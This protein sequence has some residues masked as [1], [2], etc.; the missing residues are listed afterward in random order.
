MPDSQ[1]TN[2]QNLPD[3]DESVR[4]QVSLGNCEREPIH[5]PGSIQPHGGL[6]AFEPATGTI[7][8][9]S[10]N[11]GQWLPV[12]ALPV[13]G[14]SM[15]DVLGEE[16]YGHVIRELTG[17]VGGVMRHSIVELK[18][19]P[20]EGQP[21]PLEA[22]IHLYRGVGFLEVDPVRCQ[23]PTRDWMQEFEDAIDIL[24]STVDL[25]DLLRRTAQR[26][27]RLTGFD[28]VM[29]YRFDDRWNGCVIADEHE[30][31]ME[32][33]YDLH[34]PASDIPAQA[35]ELYKSNMVRYIAD[36]N[37]QPVPVIPWLDRLKKRPLDMSHAALRAISPIHIQY[38]QNMG[39]GSTLTLSLI[40]N[41]RL[42]G[43]IACHHNSPTAL[44]LR[45]SRACYA[46][47]VTVSCMVNMHIQR[48]KILV[49]AAN[50]ETRAR[51]IS[52]F[53]QSHTSLEDILEQCGTDL[54]KLGSASGGAFWRG[55]EVYPFGLWP[56]RE[57]AA[58]LID[59]AQQTLQSTREDAVFVERADVQPK[60]MPDELR[61]VCGMAMI[62]LDPFATCGLL[63]L[64]PEY[65]REVFW[66]G[67]PDKPVQLETDADGRMK[68]SPRSSFA[69][70][71]TQVQ[72]LSRPWSELDREALRGLLSLRE[73]LVVRDSLH[74]VILSNLHFRSLVNLQSDAYWQVDTS[75]RVQVLSKPLII[76]A[77]A[78]EGQKL[79][80]LFA[81]C[82]DAKAVAQL[83]DAL[84]SRKSFR[85]LAITGYQGEERRVFEYQFNGEPLWDQD[86]RITG[87]HG[88][89]SDL[90]ERRQYEDRLLEAQLAAD[91]ANA[92]K[93]QFLAHM[94]HEIRTPLNAILGLTQL[95]ERGELRPDERGL[96]Q[97]IGESGHSLLRIINDILD[98]SKIEAGQLRMESRPYNPVQSLRQVLQLFQPLART[99][100]LD[101]RLE[102]A[103]GDLPPAVM[104]D[105]LR[106]EQIL[107]NLVSN[108]IKFTERGEIVASL[109]SLS[110]DSD[111][112][113]RF[114][115]RDTGIG[116]APDALANLFQ[117]FSQADMTIT[118]HYGGT[119]LGLAICKRLVDLMGGVIG[120]NSVVGDGSTFWL[121]I[122][123][124]RAADSNSHFGHLT[125]FPA[126]WAT[127]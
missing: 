95:L 103:E 92:A 73:I 4:F 116:I 114:E 30:Q 93:S 11:V 39:V 48:Q 113:L 97:Q 12:G 99:K 104:G 106:L 64:R 59:Y 61:M 117:S 112:R 94:S 83:T 41:E 110:S 43:L 2:P 5:I 52:A 81:D 127:V 70:W 22:F 56:A 111:D 3:L 42:W 47:A 118:R 107:I 46:L 51:V 120:V 37:Y 125:R 9:S 68:L 89:I 10:R 98:L 75:G 14:R 105:T 49:G 21:L 69:R 24:R 124:E 27:K 66:G 7:L 88:T 86:G 15:S 50:D 90:S 62:S 96:V 23:M 20:H 109:R 29:I 54:L 74:Q 32:S 71:T 8:H 87:M 34:Y 119:G 28:R 18:A 33:F 65:R 80:E 31:G 55:D 1:T 122:P 38:L 100:G 13:M 63:W 84:N 53:N 85:N 126:G 19:R 57:R 78:N 40:V 91:E 108:A 26:V 76:G 60:L 77:N 36:V 35:R 44:P 67:D 72:G 25:E 45:L 58:S 16:A 115:V 17:S 121:E 82:C 101:L 102:L 79:P 123:F 6:L